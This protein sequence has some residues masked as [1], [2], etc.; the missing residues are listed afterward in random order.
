MSDCPAPALPTAVD[1]STDARAA[2]LEKFKREQQIV[3]YLNRGVSV[4]EIA[5]RVGLSEKRMRAVIREIIARRAPPEE[6]LAIQMSRL[7]EALLVAFSAMTGANLKAVDRVVRI[8]REL[9]RYNGAFAALGRQRPDP[10]RLEAPVE[11]VAAYGLAL[12]CQA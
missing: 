2:R 3:D 9:D 6:F 11:A 4:P 8:V 5:A 12:I 7:N 1:P 10:E